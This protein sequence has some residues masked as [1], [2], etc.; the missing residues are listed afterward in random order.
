MLAIATVSATKQG[1]ARTMQMLSVDCTI[2]QLP[3]W[4][5]NKSSL[6]YMHSSS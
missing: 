3:I 4:T 1:K 2:H 5:F 6:K